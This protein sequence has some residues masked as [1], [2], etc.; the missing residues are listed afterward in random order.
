MDNPYEGKMA[1]MFLQFQDFT[2]SSAPQPI[3]V[4][5]SVEQGPLYPGN[6]IYLASD[7]YVETSFPV[8]E[9]K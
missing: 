1:G 8:L 7:L 2:T 4:D 5:G 9:S 3:I 6:A